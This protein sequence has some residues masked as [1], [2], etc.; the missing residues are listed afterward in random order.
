MGEPITSMALEG[1]SIWI[2]S[3]VDV[4]RYEAGDE[5]R[6]RFCF[7]I[8]IDNPID[9]SLLQPSG[10]NNSVNISVW[11]AN[12]GPYYRWPTYASLGC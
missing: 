11:V 9:I 1:N 12:S 4:I 8:S 5:V 10:H 7:P 2:T 6:H 3:G